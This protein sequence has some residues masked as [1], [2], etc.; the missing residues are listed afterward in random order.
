MAHAALRL[1]LAFTTLLLRIFEVPYSVMPGTGQEEF[2]NYGGR[3]GPKSPGE[4]SDIQPRSQPGIPDARVVTVSAAVTEVRQAEGTATSG[5]AKL[6]GEAVKQQARERRVK[7]SFRRAV[8]RAQASA[9]G[10]TMYR[11]RRLTIRQLGTTPQQQ[12]IPVTT[13]AIQRSSP[14]RGLRILT[15]NVGGLCT[16]TH[17]IFMTWLTG[18]RNSYDIIFLQETHYGLG[19]TFTEYKVP[20]WSVIS[21]PDPQH[22]WAG[23]AIYISNRVAGSSDIR[24]QELVPGRLLHARIPIGNG[25]QLTHIDLINVYQWAWDNDAAKQR[26]AKRQAVWQR[27]GRLLNSLPR[28]NVR[29]MAGDFNCNLKADQQHV[30]PGTFQGQGRAGYPDAGEFQQVMTAGQMCALNTWGPRRRS[31]TYVDPLK[32]HSSQIDFIALSLQHADPQAR[33][34]STVPSIDFSPWREGGKHRAVTAVIRIPAFFAKVPPATAPGLCRSSLREALRHNTPQAQALDLQLQQQLAQASIASAPEL[35]RVMHDCCRQHF[36]LG[37]KQAKPRAWQDPASMLDVKQ[38]WTKYRDLKAFYKHHRTLRLRGRSVGL[39]AYAFEAFRRHA[40]FNRCQKALRQRGR[41]R[42]KAVIHEVLQAAEDAAKVGDMHALYQHVRRL[43]PKAPRERIQIRGP[44]NSILDPRQEFEAIL[45]YFTKLYSQGPANA[46]VYHLSHDYNITDDEILYSLKQ[47]TAGKAVPKDKVPPDVWKRCATILLPYVQML[48]RQHLRA[49]AIALPTD[50]R[51]GWLHLLPKPNKPTKI[52]ANLRPIALQCPLGKCLARI[53]KTR[54]LTNLLPRL[55][56][57]PQYAYLPGRSTYNA[58]SRIAQHCRNARTQLAGLRREV[59]DRRAGR[60]C[61][62]AEGAALLSID[63]SKAF[64]QVSHEY[65]AASMRHLGIDEDTIHLTLALHQSSYHILHHNHEGHIML[66]NGI[67]QGCV[68]SPLLW[69]CVT[70]YMLHRLAERTDSAWVRDEVTAFADDFISAFTLHS[71]ADAHHLATRIQHLFDVLREAGMQVNAEKSRFLIKAVGGPLHSWLSKRS[72][73]Y[74]G[75]LYYDMGTPFSPLPLVYSPTIDYLG[76]VVSYGPFEQQSVDKRLQAARANQAQLAKF[77]FG[78]KGL[79]QA[80]K[81]SMYRT[82]IRSAALYG[83][84]ALGITAKSLKALHAF[85]AKALR[86]IARSPRHLT[87][88]SNDELYTRLKFRPVADT[89]KDL[90]SG[91]IREL[92]HA[93]TQFPGKEQELPWQTLLRTELLEARAMLKY[94]TLVPCQSQGYPCPECGVYFSE[95]RIMRIHCAKAHK[96]SL[97]PAQFAQAQA[98]N[99]TDFTAHCVDGMP[100]CKHCH[101]RFRKWRGFQD[102]I[103]RHCPALHF[104]KADCADTVE[105]ASQAVVPVS[106]SA[107]GDKQPTEAQSHVMPDPPLYDKPDTRH[108]LA[109]DWVSFAESNGAHL[110]AYCVFCAQWCSKDKGGLKNHIRRQHPAHWQQRDA[111]VR[112]LKAHYRLKYKGPCRVCSFTPASSASHPPACSGYFQACLMHQLLHPEV[113]LHDERCRGRDPVDVREA[114]PPRQHPGGSTPTP[115][116]GQGKRGPRHEVA[117]ALDQGPAGKGPQLEPG[118]GLGNMAE[119]MEGRGSEPEPESQRGRAE[120]G[121]RPVG[122]PGP[123]TRRHGSRPTLRHFFHALLQHP[124]ND[125][126]PH[127]VRHRSGMEAAEGAEEAQPVPE[128]HLDHLDPQRHEGKDGDGPPRGGPPGLGET[129]LDYQGQP[130]SLGLHDLQ[131]DDRGAGG[132]LGSTTPPSRQGQGQH[133]AH[134]RAHQHGRAIDE[135]PRHAPHGPDLPLGGPPLR[136]HGLQ[137]RS[138]S[139]RT[140][141]A[142]HVPVQQCMPFPDRCQDE[143]GQDETPAIGSSTGPD[144][145]EPP[146]CHQPVSEREEGRRGRKALR[147]LPNGSGEGGGGKGRRHVEPAGAEPPVPR[148]ACRPAAVHLQ[149]PHNICYLNSCVTALLW[150]GQQRVNSEAFFGLLGPALRSCAT[151]TPRKPLY[152]PGLMHWTPHLRGWPELRRQHD[153]A[154]FWAYLLAIAQPSGMAGTWESRENRGGEAHVH[155]SAMLWTPIPMDLPA[156]GLQ[157]LVEGWSAQHY[158]HALAAETPF[159]TVQIKRF[160]FH[161]GRSHKRTDAIPLRPDAAVQVPI[162]CTGGGTSIELKPYRLVFA[163]IHTGN[164]PHAGHYQAALS[165]GSRFFLSDDRVAARPMKAQEYQWAAS[166]CYLLGFLRHE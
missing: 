15:K 90:M 17:D 118:L 127:A 66:C 82:C 43:A 52:P 1:L 135:I 38:L 100:T 59:H 145:G 49:G 121:G 114:L 142:P 84:P 87:H 138:A 99:D 83:L 60:A 131:P 128:G 150:L 24:F 32:T 101:Q 120:G 98:R 85:E 27:L 5:V 34:S 36:P 53:I 80:H 73:R 35:T 160:S 13:A 148:P 115:L 89:L 147:P 61:V 93:G 77:L 75:S 50:W 65:L 111:V 71:V 70:T 23:V 74:K 42:R 95:Q 94:T 88:E 4:V 149:N 7:R 57:V 105:P 162:F 39:V 44:D 21:S 113:P 163:I 18:P 72:Y 117:Q 6:S 20:G 126:D 152:L 134:L 47:Q 151:G 12:Q 51:D 130:S 154:E 8:R 45:K 140:P 103:L 164:T 76:I 64:D 81:L 58:I 30:G 16:A 41:E 123:Q 158:T 54:I 159:F 166:N 129:L 62:Q 55:D 139:R 19:R 22:R 9:D 63:M 10:A 133:P 37:P 26:L 108:A 122:P 69:V 92:E 157:S 33:R 86:A 141:W 153:V 67:R 110:S 102:H 116:P 112:R 136:P 68:L 132:G 137:S 29:C 109:T 124:R 165:C 143:A 40:A 28:R 155:D 97:V 156:T 146:G 91:R 25:K 96:K 14:E 125:G 107:A 48:F 144:R 56:D 46:A 79:T 11:G 2:F 161:D 119:R 78:R 104:R 3:R 31:A 106:Q